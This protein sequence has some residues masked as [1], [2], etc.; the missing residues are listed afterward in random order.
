MLLISLSLSLC[1][2]LRGVLLHRVN[3]DRTGQ[4]LVFVAVKKWFHS[5]FSK[6]LVVSV[7]MYISDI[8]QSQCTH[9]YVV[10]I[11]LHNITNNTLSVLATGIR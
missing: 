6:Q 9:V 7:Q 2:S 3:V 11:Y 8:T 4:T 1:L 10:K 5:G